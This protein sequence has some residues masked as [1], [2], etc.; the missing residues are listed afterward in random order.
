MLSVLT[1]IVFLMLVATELTR[2]T[3]VKILLDLLPKASLGFA[4]IS[5]QDLYNSFTGKK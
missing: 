2:P 1:S 3:D 5:A 4:L